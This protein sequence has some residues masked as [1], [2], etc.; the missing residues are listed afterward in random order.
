MARDF[1][2]VLFFVCK[3]LTQKKK[4]S[5]TEKSEKIARPPISS[6]PRK[7]ES[8][9]RPQDGKNLKKYMYDHVVVL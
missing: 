7:H 4:K 5:G 9:A 6:D 2:I 8:T 3:K 1:I